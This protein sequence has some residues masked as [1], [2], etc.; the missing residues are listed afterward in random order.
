MKDR[1]AELAKLRK[2]KFDMLQAQRAAD[3]DRKAREEEAE[4]LRK[5]LEDLKKMQAERDK[6]LRDLAEAEAQR[7]RDEEARERADR[8]REAAERARRE[9]ERNALDQDAAAKA[10]WAAL[11]K[12]RDDAMRKLKVKKKEKKNKFWENFYRLFSGSARR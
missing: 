1:E 5:Q 7:K 12:E 3:A 10:R 9:A 2:E 4:R 8:E 11:E 6:A